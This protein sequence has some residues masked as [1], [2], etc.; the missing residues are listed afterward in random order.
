M[1]N[2]YQAADRMIDLISDNYRLLQVMSRFGMSLGF[3]N[4]TVDEVCQMYQVD[5]TT[6]LAI[7]NFVNTGYSQTLEDVESLSIPALINYLKQSHIYFLKFLLP[8]IR[9]DLDEAL[10]HKNIHITP[11]ILQLLDYYI[12][13]IG[14]HMSY[15]DQHIFPYVENLLKGKIEENFEITT[16]SKSH[17]SV[18]ESLH[19]IKTILI[20]YNPSDKSDNQLNAVLYSIYC[21]EDELDAHCKAEDYIFLPAVFNLENKVRNERRN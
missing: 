10:D 13:S 18:D 4:K 17:S 7:I 3:G 8:K 16:F 11:L 12:D 6:F 21:C 9:K 14:K 2:N 1:S 15:E 19:E 5:T 20:K